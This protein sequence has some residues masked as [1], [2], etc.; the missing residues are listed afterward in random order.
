M[1]HIGIL[2]QA[3]CGK[4][5]TFILFIKSLEARGDRVLTGQRG[6]EE[7][8]L[9]ITVDFIRFTY[10]GFTH[11]LY[12][13]GGH[14]AAITDYYRVF[15]LRNADR[16]LCM[17]DLTEPLDEQLEF[18]ERLGDIPAKS[19]VVTFNKF[20]LVDSVDV[21]KDFI[22]PTVNWFEKR[23]KRT[24]QKKFI[25]VALEKKGFA[26]YQQNAVDAI[27]DLCEWAP[28]KAFDVWTS[29]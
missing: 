16:F 10:Q 26:G 17:I 9:T 13:T 5:S 7:R 28:E 20:D 15:V 18:F 25:T 24:V 8:E 21:E 11:T 14:R 12:G 27:L 1:V 3:D 4:T 29:P 6:G 2:G 23:L 22:E 19:I